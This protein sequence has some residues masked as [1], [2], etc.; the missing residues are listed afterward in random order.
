MWYWL[1]HLIAACGA[2]F[3]TLFFV[4]TATTEAAFPSA[5]NFSASTFDCLTNPGSASRNAPISRSRFFNVFDLLALIS[6]GDLIILN[7]LDFV[8]SDYI[9]TAHSERNISESLRPS[10]HCP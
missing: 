1:R 7:S 6:G 9:F 5:V 3:P 4:A 10:S 8:A 2:Y